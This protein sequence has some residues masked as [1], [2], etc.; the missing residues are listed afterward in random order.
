MLVV[1]TAQYYGAQGGAPPVQ[2]AQAQQATRPRK[3]HALQIIDPTTGK[4]V[5][6]SKK[7]KAEEEEKVRAEAGAIISLYL[8]SG[9][10]RERCCGS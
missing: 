6:L 7:G 2:P 4:A 1:P 8:C 9:C 5:E 10:K 3:S